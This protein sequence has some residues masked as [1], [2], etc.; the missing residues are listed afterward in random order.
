MEQL[1]APWRMEYIRGIDAD[2]SK[3]ECVFCVD[4]TAKDDCSKMI[5]HRGKKCFVIMNLFP[6]NNGHLM[7]IPYRHRSDI[8]SI[9]TEESAELWELIC[10]SKHILKEAFHPDGFNIGINQGRS[11]GAGIDAHL[12]VHI[13]PRWSGDTNFM[14]VIGKT[15]VISQSL[16]DAYSTLL[17]Y[18]Q[19]VGATSSD[20]PSGR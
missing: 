17:P 10:M 20:S 19:S 3:K 12:H 14:P 1:W 7:V 16:E 2:T 4:K 18:F 15:K 9:D 8:C 6:Y 11:A 13:V 5:L